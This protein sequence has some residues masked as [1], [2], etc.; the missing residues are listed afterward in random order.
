M[1]SKCI[2]HSHF[3]PWCRLEIDV[4]RCKVCCLQAQHLQRLLAI[5]IFKI[6]ICYVKFNHI[7]NFFHALDQMTHSVCMCAC[8]L[9]LVETSNG[10]LTSAND[11]SS[12][13]DEFDAL[14]HRIRVLFS[15]LVQRTCWPTLQ[16]ATSLPASLHASLAASYPAPTYRYPFPGSLSLSLRQAQLNNSLHRYK[17]R[18]KNYLRLLLLL[19]SLQ[20]RNRSLCGSQLRD[21]K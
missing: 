10:R 5:K 19:F 7:L 12:G 16:L 2:W 20:L 17:I 21:L 4:V 14:Q 9:Q 15:V 6:H 1:S 18:I 3:A 8:N 11:V 13:L